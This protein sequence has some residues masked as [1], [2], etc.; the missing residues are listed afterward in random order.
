MFCEYCGSVNFGY[1]DG[2][3]CCID[4][5]TVI[6][7]NFLTVEAP[8]PGT[9]TMVTQQQDLNT[10]ESMNNANRHYAIAHTEA[11]C[12]K[13]AEMLKLGKAYEDQILFLI[14]KIWMG[15]LKQGRRALMMVAG[16]AYIVCRQNRL[17][18]TMLDIAQ[19]LQGHVFELGRHYQQCLTELGNTIVLEEIDPALYIERSVT[20]LNLPKDLQVKICDE[21]IRFVSMAKDDW[22]TTGRRPSAIT[23][24]AIAL[25]LEYNN[26]KVELQVVSDILHCST[27]TVKIRLRE[28]KDDFIR[29]GKTILPWGSEMNRRNIVSNMEEILKQIDFLAEQKKASGSKAPSPLASPISDDLDIKP[30]SLDEEIPHAVPPS[31]KAWERLKEKRRVKVVRAKR[32]IAKLFNENPSLKETFANISFELESESPVS[33]IKKQPLDQ[34]K[35]DDEDLAIE[36]LLLSG[37]NEKDIIE[38]LKSLKRSMI[39]KKREAPVS[40]AIYLGNGDIPEEDLFEFIKTPS[41]VELTQELKRARS[42]CSTPIPTM[43]NEI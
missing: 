16:C 19:G 24:A 15:K 37:T 12:T 41:E 29:I 6:S 36:E 40:D 10:S 1:D 43:T 34:A 14:N 20:Q 39:T 35:L 18:I 31:Q 25:S 21:S 4:C 26:Q 17:P 22:I 8:I 2:Q 30:S 9:G 28:L 3:E 38:D 11:L 33:P 23:A 7:E 42:Q 5:G 27:A 13:V 32:R